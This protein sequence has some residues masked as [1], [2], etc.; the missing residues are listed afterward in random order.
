M[1]R[2]NRLDRTLGPG[3]LRS[4]TLWSCAAL[5]GATLLACGGGG[6]GTAQGSLRLALTDAPACGYD[7]V[8][9]T[10]DKVR[11]HTSA[12]AQDGDAGW[13]ELSVSPRQR[14]DLLALT[15]GVLQELGSLPLPAGQYQQMRLVLADNLAG[16]PLAN[17]VVPTG[18]T[19][20]LPLTTPSGQQSGTK[21]Q[22][23]FEI[24]AGQVADLVLDF[25]ACKSLVSAGASGRIHLKPVVAVTPRLTTQ[26]VGYVNPS[27]AAGVVVSTR[28]ADLRWRATVPDASG[29]FV[30]AYLPE[31]TRYTVVL[32]GPHLATTAVTGVPVSLASGTTLINTAATP[33]T[34]AESDMA[35]VSGQVGNAQ[36]QPLTDA[37][38]SALQDL[39]SGEV[40][41]VSNRL[42]DPQ[43]AR[44]TL[45][46]PR[47]APRVAPY[48]AGA[49]LAFAPDT[50]AAGRYRLQARAPGY[51]QQ[52]SSGRFN[53]G[54]EGSTTPLDLLL[55]P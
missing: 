28:D 4:I 41:E 50:S 44:F 34:L 11:V 18:S 30:L 22:A 29:R 2:L 3:P 13:Q 35:S 45:T 26:I 12:T 51:T 10:I 40:I 21:L 42:V 15:N 23:R 36:G 14:L 9:I 27:Q 7:H 1:N 19:Q 52:I 32:S 49:P 48:V 43:D 33:V 17:A 25:D 6:S 46:L 20:E 31:N 24:T 5:A 38:V 54:A 37:Q 8:Y 53:L 47:Q 55:A 16:Q 39:A